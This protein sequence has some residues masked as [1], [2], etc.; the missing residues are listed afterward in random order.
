MNPNQF[1]RQLSTIKYWVVTAVL[2]LSVTVLIWQG[3]FFDNIAAMASPSENL[4]AA[5]D[6]GD[7]IQNKLGRDTE[8]AKDFV[9]ETTERLKKT[10]K[11]NAN[12]VDRVTDKETNFVGRK[13]KKDQA[14]IEDK[15]EK[16]SSRTKKAIDDTKNVVERTVDSVKD[17]L[18][19]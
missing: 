5:M 12:K 1:A 7:T 18:G 6:L 13:A 10:A 15:A 14:R 17:A 16:D 19:S 4:V 11:T 9:E 3:S 8:R 2:F